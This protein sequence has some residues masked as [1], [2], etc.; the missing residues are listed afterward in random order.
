MR[1]CRETRFP[2]FVD[3]VESGTELE[4]A[5]DLV[6]ARAFVRFFEGSSDSE[7]MNPPA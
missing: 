4:L 3:D 6:E 7:R 5:E 1:G 2:L